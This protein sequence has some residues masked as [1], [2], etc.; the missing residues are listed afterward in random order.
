VA[1]FSILYLYKE[2]YK[3]P[4]TGIKADRPTPKESIP[5][6]MT[7]EETSLVIS[8]MSGQYQMLAMLMYGCGLRRSEAV[9]LR[10]K[11]IDLGNGQLLIWCS[12]HKKSRTV[13]IP[14]FL[15]SVLRKQIDE[16][17]GWCNHDRENRTGGVIIPRGD[18]TKRKAV[19]DPRWYWLF[20]SS[21]LSRDP[22]STR[23]GRW[24]LDDKH[25]GDIVTATA[26]RVGLLKR[27]TCHTFRHSYATHLLMSGVNIRSIQRLLG[28]SK[29]TTTMIYTHVSLFADQETPNP[30]DRLALNAPLSLRLACG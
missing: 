17:I 14:K 19:F 11:D 8:G 3:T 5:V 2:V 21:V 18:A 1:F 20:C 10:L 16:A 7:A 4:L 23:I 26:K 13:P 22:I 6:V 28:H 12:K 27:V 25:L 29:V 15:V 9:S 24:H 30:L